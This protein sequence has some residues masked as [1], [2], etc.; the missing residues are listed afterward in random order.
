MSLRWITIHSILFAIT[1]DLSVIDRFFYRMAQVKSAQEKLED[2]L[3]EMT[4]PLA[5]S[6]EDEDLERLLKGRDREGDPMLAFIKKKKKRKL[7]L[8]GKKGDHHN[9]SLD[10][11]SV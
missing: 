7:E 6:R 5:R 1:A 8:S 10:V 3:Y 4:K 2:E 11:S 9:I